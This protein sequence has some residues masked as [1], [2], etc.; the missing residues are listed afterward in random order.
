MKKELNIYKKHSAMKWT[1]I[2]IFCSLITAI[3]HG[4]TEDSTYFTLDE[5]KIYALEHHYKIKNA[6]NEIE[7]ARQQIIET[8]ALGLPQVNINGSFSNFINLPIQVVDA[9][10]INPMAQEGETISFRAGTEFSASGSLQASQLLF[11]GS[12]FVG[13]QASNYFAKFQATAAQ[14]TEEEVLFSV[15][16]SYELVAVAQK[17]LAFADSIVTLT[18]NLVSK[19]QNYYELGFI[20][21][22]DLDQLKYSLHS[23]KNTRT[24]AKVQLENTL[25]MLK[26]SMGYPIEFPIHLSNSLEDL[27]NYA[28]GIQSSNDVYQNLNYQLLEKRVHLNEL[29]MKNNKMNYLPTLS[30]F[31]DQTY[32]A[33]RNKFDFFDDLP[34]F[35]Q[36]VWGLQLNV[37]IFSGGQR[38]ARTSQAKIAWM[39]EQNNLEY[40]GESLK[41]QEITFKNNLRCA[42]D[43]LELQKQSIELAKTIYANSVIREKIGKGNSILV[44]QKQQQLMVAQTQYVTTLIELFS[45]KLDLDKLYNNIISTKE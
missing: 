42:Q 6:Q 9:S 38:Y 19:Q 5:A 37:P 26:L 21:K 32:N 7:I 1:K 13:L 3:L 27:V 16:Q 33:Y 44:T 41:L 2:V 45:A 36:T 22:E 8:R 39:K 18:E 30:A 35:P 12:Y 29:D 14:M 43:K 34:W 25:S 4:Q 23:S 11:N 31:F 24:N 40:L 28:N 20:E 17:N 10:F 15:I